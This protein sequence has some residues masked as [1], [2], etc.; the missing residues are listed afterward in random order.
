M[1]T[2]K[3]PVDQAVV[4]IPNE[5]T[6]DSASYSGDTLKA[7]YWAYHIRKEHGLEALEVVFNSLS[8]VGTNS[9]HKRWFL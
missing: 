8:Y 6:H 3:C 4:T 1:A 2:F 7:M 9:P 5:W